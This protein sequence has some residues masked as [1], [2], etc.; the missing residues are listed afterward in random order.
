M[1]AERS[2]SENSFVAGSNIPTL[3]AS[4]GTKNTFPEGAST[5]PKYFPSLE[6]VVEMSTVEN[7]FVEGSKI[8]TLSAL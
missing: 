1:D 3:C 7:T 2:K 4:R 5:P 6:M 8:P